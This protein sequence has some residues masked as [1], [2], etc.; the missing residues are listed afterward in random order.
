M[1]VPAPRK[2]T[3]VAG[4]GERADQRRELLRRRQGDRVT[5]AVRGDRRRERILVDALDRRLAG[6][7]DVGDDHAVGVVEAGGESVEQRSEPRIAVRLH[8]R[9]HLAAV[10]AARAAL[11]TAAIS[12][13]WW[14]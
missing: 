11:S 12:T 13:G 10:A 4:R 2:T 14:P 1:I 3:I 8:D 5:V 6:R 9:D 7:I